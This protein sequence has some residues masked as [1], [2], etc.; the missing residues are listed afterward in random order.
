MWK[1]TRVSL[2]ELLKFNLNKIYKLSFTL[3]VVLNS[4]TSNSSKIAYS[5][6]TCKDA[7]PVRETQNIR[8][9]L[10]SEMPMYYTLLPSP[11]VLPE[12]QIIHLHVDLCAQQKS[13]LSI[14]DVPY[15]RYPS[16][17]LSVQFFLLS[18]TKSVSHNSIL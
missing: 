5:P 1:P 10:Q 7:E 11:V 16:F 2:D 17:V 3:I 9:T 15:S 13:Q 4:K 12:N 14:V 6:L 18:V 8:S